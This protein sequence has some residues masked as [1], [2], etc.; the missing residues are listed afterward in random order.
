M[1]S[2]AKGVSVPIVSTPA[3]TV[4]FMTWM[5]R[6]EVHKPEAMGPL[7]KAFSRKG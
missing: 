6:T 2:K 5:H 1:S 4:C 3:F 7:A